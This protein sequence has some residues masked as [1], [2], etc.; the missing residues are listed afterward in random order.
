MSVANCGGTD[1]HDDD[2]TKKS[3][4]LRKKTLVPT[5]LSP[6][7]PGR[8]S[9]KERIPGTRVVRSLAER[10]TGVSPCDYTRRR[11][12]TRGSSTYYDL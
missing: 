11:T 7:T 8:G 5:L 9:A 6:F 10:T 2:E 4:S 1:Q 3:R 12:E